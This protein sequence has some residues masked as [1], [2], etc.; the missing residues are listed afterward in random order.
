MSDIGIFY[1]R[2]FFKY[3]GG[4]IYIL[5]F[6]EE[7]LT[8]QSFL[9]VRQYVEEVIWRLTSEFQKYHEKGKKIFKSYELT[10]KLQKYTP[11]VDDLVFH[12][13]IDLLETL[14]Y[15]EEQKRKAFKPPEITQVAIENFVEFF[16][17]QAFYAFDTNDIVWNKIFNAENPLTTAGDI[18]GGFYKGI[19]A[20]AKTTLVSSVSDVG[21]FSQRIFIKH[22]EPLTFL[23][24]VDELKYLEFPITEIEKIVD[25]ILG[26]LAE[27]FMEYYLQQMKTV[28]EIQIQPEKK[29]NIDQLV[30]E[31]C[32]N[33][34]L[35]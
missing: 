16:G 33:S 5:A 31:A 32:V 15:L 29:I 4:L 14:E 28:D 22:N 20:F 11:E 17:I 2:L 25:A 8:N 7:K 13:C 24:V 6:D 35:K 30:V 9:N 34:F 19:Q 1:Q 26:Y 18:M 10:D 27:K 21:M 23:L 12:G 3:H